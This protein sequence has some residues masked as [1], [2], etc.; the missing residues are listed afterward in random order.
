MK[1]T[2]PSHVVPTLL[3]AHCL[4]TL[5]KKSKEYSDS[6][7]MFHNFIL[8]ADMQEV[9][10]R[11]AIKGMSSKHFASI[12]DIINGKFNSIR[13]IDFIKLC[14]EKFGDAFNYVIIYCSH[15]N[16]EQP[17]SVIKEHYA[18]RDKFNHIDVL[19]YYACKGIFSRFLRPNKTSSLNKEIVTCYK[20]LAALNN[21]FE[22]LIDRGDNE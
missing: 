14:L 21:I 16:M 9:S 10:V 17:E 19:N 13:H 4:K 1:L 22:G 11:T 12:L 18:N 8:A 15:I 20:T 6:R 3:S 5:K 2:K 7:S